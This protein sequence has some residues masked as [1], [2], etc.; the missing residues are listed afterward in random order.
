MFGMKSQAF[1]H[2]RH[3]SSVTIGI[4]YLFYKAGDRNSTGASFF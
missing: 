4:D 1:W 2:K 3:S